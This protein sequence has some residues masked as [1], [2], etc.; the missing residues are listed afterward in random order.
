[1]AGMRKI[2]EKMKC[3]PNGISLR[4]ADRVLVAHGYRLDR[5]KGSHRQYINQSG[6]VLTVVDNSPLKKAYVTAILERIGEN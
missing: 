5:Q 4:E 1:M 6:D 3:Q 2:I